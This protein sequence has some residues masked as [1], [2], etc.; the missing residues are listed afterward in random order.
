MS[1]IKDNLVDVKTPFQH[2]MVEIADYLEPLGGT[3]LTLNILGVLE[4]HFYKEMDIAEHPEN[5]P[6]LFYEPPV[7]DE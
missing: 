2:K 6:E 1:I 7:D 3:E 4:K 5:Y